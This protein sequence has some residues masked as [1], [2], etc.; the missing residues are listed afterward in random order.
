VT[1]PP[2]FDNAPGGIPPGAHATRPQYFLSFALLGSIVPFIS[3]L[4]AERGLSKEQIGT[5]WAVSSLGV[6]LTPQ[7]V[8]LLADTA[9]A[10]RL[11]MAGLFAATGLFLGGLIPA[12]GYWP[13]LLLYWLHALALQPIFPLQD[14]VHFAAQALRRTADLPEAPY[15]TVRVWGT[16]GYILPGAVLYFF[17][18]PGRPMTPVLVCAVAICAAGVVYALTLLPRTAPPPRGESHARLPTAAAWRAIREPHVLVFCVA[19]F[20]IH[21]ASQAYYQYYPL[22]LTER[23]GIDKR[24]VGLIANVGVVVEIF[25]MLAFAALHR[26]LGLRRLMYFGALAVALRL[27]LLAFFPHPAVAVA[28]QAVHGLTVLVIHVVPP[29]FIDRH[30]TDAYRNSIQGLYA[31]AFAG[32]GKVVGAYVSGKVAQHSLAGAFNLSATACVVAAGLLYFA[33]SESGS[34]DENEKREA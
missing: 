18:A 15:H 24:W 22:H 10:P 28:T 20:L 13:I 23:S 27:Y 16:V 12:H 30:A 5:V 14:G 1:R 34:R 9:I 7:F 2:V 19:M 21:L 29:M 6:I 17:L 26:R 25:F 8:T 4:F 31:M 33:F 3:V 32:S 11:L